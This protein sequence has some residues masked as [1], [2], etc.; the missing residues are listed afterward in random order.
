ME[1]DLASPPDD[2]N[3]LRE[4]AE[5]QRLCLDIA[6]IIQ[7]LEQGDL[8]SNDTVIVIESLEYA[9]NNGVL[10]YYY[11][12][13]SK[14]IT[15]CCINS[16]VVPKSLRQRILN[17]ILPPRLSSLLSIHPTQIFLETHACRCPT[18]YS[19]LSSLPAMQI[20]CKFT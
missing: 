7:Y 10:Y 13:R 1:D 5:Q 20:A 15:R 9:I 4:I 18:P 3:I 2:E 6:P 8:P 19:V 11:L 17:G 16:L 14:G 12:P